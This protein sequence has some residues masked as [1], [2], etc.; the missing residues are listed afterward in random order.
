MVGRKG[1]IPQIARRSGILL[2]LMVAT[3]INLGMAAPENAVASASAA[4]PQG[5]ITARFDPSTGIL[6]ARGDQ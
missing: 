5:R 2:T 4:A 1:P 6:T 3:A